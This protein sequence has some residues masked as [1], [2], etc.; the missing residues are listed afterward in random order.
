MNKESS[1]PDTHPEIDARHAILV[2]PSQPI[3]RDVLRDNRRWLARGLWAPLEAGIEPL[4]AVLSELGI[5]A[6]RSG[7]AALRMWGETGER[8][9]SF[10]AAVEPVHLEAM[11]DHVRVH[12]VRPETLSPAELEDLL[13]CI[14]AELPGGS[15]RFLQIG[16]RAYL[17]GGESFDTARCSAQCIDGLEPGEFLPRGPGAR[18]HDR[19]TGELQLLLHEALVNRVREAN[20]QLPVNSMW[21][22]GG[23]FAPS[24]GHQALPELVGHDRLF[25]GFWYSQGGRVMDWRDDASWRDPLPAGVVAVV[26]EECNSAHTIAGFLSYAKAQLVKGKWHRLSILVGRHFVMRLRRRDLFAVWRTGTLPILEGDPR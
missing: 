17:E 4:M 18:D 26:P 16:G 5:G 23:G 24:T 25:R 9:R 6:P 7:L 12:A 10:V 22:W 2:L 11:L 21:L 19:L 3:C 1:N 20:D 13:S 14:N 8:P 15:R